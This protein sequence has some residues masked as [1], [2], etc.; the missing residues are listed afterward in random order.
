MNTIANGGITAETLTAAHAQVA[1]T[2][3]ETMINCTHPQHGPS[4]GPGV[5]FHSTT[6]L[7]LIDVLTQW[8]P[9]P[10]ALQH[11][12]QPAPI[13]SVASSS[14]PNNFA[15]SYAGPS[16]ALGYHQGEYI[17]SFKCG[18]LQPT[19]Y[20]FLRATATTVSRSHHAWRF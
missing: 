18:L 11:H 13:L 2:Y 1:Y 16:T 17:F 15:Q 8:H 5:P 9:P 7:N 4:S 3:K 20:C 19:L 14:A 6:L 12:G 10:N